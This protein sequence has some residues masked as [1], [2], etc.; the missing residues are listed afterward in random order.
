MQII[1]CVA[2]LR[3]NTNN[4]IFREGEGVAIEAVLGRGIGLAA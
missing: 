3:E 1:D 2:Y 4:E